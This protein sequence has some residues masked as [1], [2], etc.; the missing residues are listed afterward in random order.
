M[1]MLAVQN[2]LMETGGESFY[3]EKGRLEGGVK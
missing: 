2:A 3:T 1:K